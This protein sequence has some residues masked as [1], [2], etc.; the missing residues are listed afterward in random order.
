MFKHS[1]NKGLLNL[2]SKKILIAF[3]EVVMSILLVVTFLPAKALAMAGEQTVQP[4]ISEIVANS[5]DSLAAKA[6]SGE[7]DPIEINKMGGIPVEKPLFDNLFNSQNNDE[8]SEDEASNFDEGAS[9]ASFKVRVQADGVAP[10][11]ITD[12]S[13]AREF[14]DKH[15]NIIMDFMTD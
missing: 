13:E 11:E 14:I 7:L 12:G 3:V 8:S 5:G 6:A 9:N 1:E 10:Y 4:V 2:T 15:N